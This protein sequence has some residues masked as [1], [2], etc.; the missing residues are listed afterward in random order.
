MPLEARDIRD[1]ELPGVVWIPGM[2]LRLSARAHM[3]LT[4]D[5]SL[6]P[7]P[8]PILKFL[9]KK[10]SMFGVTPVEPHRVLQKVILIQEAW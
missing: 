1:G 8:N 6:L 4:P 5:P 9:E 2:D 3:L 7:I 10:L